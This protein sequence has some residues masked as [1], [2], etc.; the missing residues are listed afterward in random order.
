M[1]SQPAAPTP[2][3]SLAVGCLALA[4]VLPLGL[5]L[6]GLRFVAHSQPALPHL[7][8]ALAVLLGGGAGLLIVLGIPA[9]GLAL[10]LGHVALRQAGQAPSWRRLR[11]IARMGLA[12][13]Y[14]S[15]GVALGGAGFIAWW[16]GTHRMHLVW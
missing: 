10:G 15:L 4:L 16:L 9:S 5:A 8:T 11:L 12:L 2:R 6:F 1:E 3:P 13:G 14:L 7:P